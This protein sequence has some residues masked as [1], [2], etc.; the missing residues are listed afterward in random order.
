MLELP[1][2]IASDHGAGALAA[3]PSGALLSLRTCARFGDKSGHSAGGV[4]AWD[5]GKPGVDNHA[6]AGDG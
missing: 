1:L 6:H 2:G 5:A 3:S 4:A